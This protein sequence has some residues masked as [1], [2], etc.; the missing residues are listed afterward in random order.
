MLRAT[1]PLRILSALAAFV[2]LNPACDQRFEFDTQPGGAGGAGSATTNA[3][4][5]SVAA[6]NGGAGG[7]PAPGGSGTAGSSTACGDLGE[8]SAGTHCVSGECVQ[9]AVDAECAVYG[10][11]RCELTRHRCVACLGSSDC[12]PGFACDLLANRCMQSCAEDEACPASAHGCDER[13]QVCYQCDEDREC[14]TSS[15]GHL[16]ASDGSGCVRCRKETDCPAQHCDQLSGRCVECRVAAD[17]G[18]RVC[19]FA[20]FTCVP[21]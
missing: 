9:C 16:C 18:S 8:C 14:A 4:S 20:T 6:T 5:S 13:R 15:L 19:N 10:F 17:C 2:S 21:N 11:P 7:S 3:G 1:R 12:L